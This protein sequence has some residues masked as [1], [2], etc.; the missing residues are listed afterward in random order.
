MLATGIPKE[1][2]ICGRAIDIPGTSDLLFWDNVHVNNTFTAGAKN[3][4]IDNPLDPYNSFLSHSCVE[5]DE[6]KNMYDGTVRTDA[7]GV[8]TVTL[9]DWFMALNENFRYQLTVVDEEGEGFV[10]AKVSRKI[11]NGRFQI[12][13]SAPGME[14][15]W[16]VTGVR[17]DAYAKANPL[18]VVSEKPATLRGKLIHPEPVGSKSRP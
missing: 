12:R 14:V 13:T 5:S 16:M 7:K 9:P 2:G 18:Q 15:C 17:K 8:A 1:H 3:F 6:M 10:M 4:K 11:Q